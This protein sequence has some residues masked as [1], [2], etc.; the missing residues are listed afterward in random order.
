MPT[1]KPQE[2]WIEA[3]RVFIRDTL[4]NKNW[5]IIENKGKAR[6]GI[7][8]ADGTRTYKYLPYQW[9]RVN[10]NEIR[11]FIEA[12]HYLHIKKGVPID[13]AFERTK[14]RAPKG[15]ILPKNKTNPKVL[16]DAWK[17]YGVY[18]VEQSGA[19]SQSTWE[20]GYAKTFR[21]L[22]QIADSQNAQDL[23]IKIGKFNEAG[24]RSREENV[25][26]IAAFLRWAT[27]KESEYLLDEELWSPPPRFNLQDFKGKKSRKL[28]EQTQKPTT[29]IEENDIF[30]L[31]ESLQLTT[32][33]KKHRQ[34]DRAKE[35]SLAI[36]LMSTYG[37]RPIEVQ[38][39]EVRRNGK[40]TL[41]C[42]YSKRTS[43]GGTEARRLFPLHP[44]WEKNW[45][46]IK[47]V[48]NKAPLPRMK[49]GAAEAFKNYM[50]FNSKWKE[51]KNKGCS[52][53]SFRHAYAMRGHLEYRF[54]PRELCVMMGHSLES[55]Q[56]YSRFF[57]EEML[58]DSFER[59]IERR[60]N[61][62]TSPKDSKN[63]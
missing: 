8:F 24:S 57:N 58:E 9:Q 36:K 39:L 28:Q 2:D 32:E 12:V 25:Q 14:S 16:L 48:K 33:E 27:S 30:E 20:K 4:G 7:R 59:A 26:R 10:A 29:P 52:G 31:L 43:A 49:A 61:M 6:L 45:E 51:L 56:Q 62:H 22:E 18:K 46:L 1:R 15:N 41:W 47:K 37:L 19:I 55:H 63:K 44:T 13:E 35:W 60:E 3:I 5:Q 34:E 38:H 50:R 21:K 42:T 53:Y 17:K 23:L 11:H 54:H 40:D